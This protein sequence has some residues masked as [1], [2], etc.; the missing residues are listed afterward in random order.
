MKNFN[1]DLGVAPASDEERREIPDYRVEVTP[2]YLRG[3]YC[4]PE[5]VDLV[6]PIV[7][8]VSGREGIDADTNNGSKRVIVARLGM[9][10]MQDGGV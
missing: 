4:P 2:E 8:D 5:G 10:A 3:A 9:S 1:A 7:P 6:I